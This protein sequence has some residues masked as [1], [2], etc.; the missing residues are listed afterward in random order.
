MEDDEAIQLLI[1]QVQEEEQVW[2]T[3]RKLGK[4]Y[5][6]T[7]STLVSQFYTATPNSRFHWN[8]KLNA[9]QE[10]QL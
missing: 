5:S 7:A 9:I 10:E 3:A 4:K 8:Y 6:I 1:E 2:K